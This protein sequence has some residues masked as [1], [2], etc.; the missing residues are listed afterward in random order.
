MHYLD[1]GTSV[2]SKVGKASM[3]FQVP[4]EWLS[5]H[6]A[7]AGQEFYCTGLPSGELEYT[8]K[9]THWCKPVKLVVRSGRY[10]ALTIPVEIA[11][12]RGIAEGSKVSVVENTKTGALV[13]SRVEER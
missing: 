12:P 3:H 5:H 8:Q 7:E 4:R 10:A 1:Y 2:V 11:R 6:N 13:V 9:P